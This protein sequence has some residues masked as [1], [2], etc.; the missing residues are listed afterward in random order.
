MSIDLIVL[1]WL[2]GMNILFKLV[3]DGILKWWI[4]EKQY[5]IN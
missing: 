5:F 1:V 4:I 3:L 2:L